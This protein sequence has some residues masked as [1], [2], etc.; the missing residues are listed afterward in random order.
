MDIDAL[1]QDFQVYLFLQKETKSINEYF[2]RLATEITNTEEGKQ[3]SQYLVTLSTRNIEIN[4]KL[5]H[6]S[7]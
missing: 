2:I 3:T 7:S 4:I 6:V 1:L 5:I